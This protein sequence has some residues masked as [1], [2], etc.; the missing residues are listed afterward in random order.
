VKAKQIQKNHLTIVILVLALVVVGKKF[1]AHL[2]DFFIWKSYKC[3]SQ[4]RDY[5]KYKDSQEN[6]SNYFPQRVG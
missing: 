1:P 3:F 2:H 5:F 4:I 6:K